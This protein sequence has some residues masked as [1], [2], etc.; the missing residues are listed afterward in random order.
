MNTLAYL[1]LIGLVSADSF[2][3]DFNATKLGDYAKSTGKSLH[4]F[5]DHNQE[6]EKEVKNI[7]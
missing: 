6:L 2:T 4:Q 3:L 5:T 7:T 1:A